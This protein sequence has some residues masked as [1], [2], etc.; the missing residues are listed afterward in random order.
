MSAEPWAAWA[1][2]ATEATVALVAGRPGTFA[3]LLSVLGT[4]TERGPMSFIEALELQV[5]FYDDQTDAQRAVFQIDRLPGHRGDWWA[6]VEPIGFRMSFASNLR[7]VAADVG[8]AF[9]W[10]VNAVMRVLK[11]ENGVV[12][13]EFDPLIDPGQVPEESRDLPFETMPRSASI[14][15]LHR[16]TGVKIT[17]RWFEAAKPTFI[18][19]APIE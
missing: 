6:T 10:N 14:A 19:H 8:V 7:S 18:V 1:E 11:V 16:W 13:V 2:E 5:S 4:V 3:G 17:Q 12:I 15:L 9:F